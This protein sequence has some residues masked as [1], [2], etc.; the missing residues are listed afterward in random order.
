M[1]RAV[2]G[3]LRELSVTVSSASEGHCD[4]QSSCLRCLVFWSCLAS[5]QISQGVALSVLLYLN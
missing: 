4:F 5:L 1:L 3:P 2:S